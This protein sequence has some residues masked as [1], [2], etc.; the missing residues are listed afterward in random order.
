[1]NERT[2]SQKDTPDA[3]TLAQFMIEY[4]R[5]YLAVGGPTSRLEDSLTNL[6]QSLNVSTEV[7]ATPTGIF[8][9]CTDIQQKAFT[10]LARIRE[11]TIDLGRL[12]WLEGLLEDLLNRK[13][14]IYSAQKILKGKHTKKT[15]YS[16]FQNLVASFVFGF[17][18]SYPLYSLTLPALLSGLIATLTWYIAG[19][20]LKHRISSAIFRDF[21][22]CLF[23]LFASGLWQQI[24][25]APYE[26][27]SIWGIV[28]MVPGLSLTTAISELAE[29]NLVS[30]TAKLT[31]A[32]LTI[33]ALG[34]A[35]M[36]FQDV[37]L[38]VGLEN[39]ALQIVK[40]SSVGPSALAIMM[41][42]TCFGI[43]F[44]VPPKSLPW[45]TLCGVLGWAVLRLNDASTPVAFG[46]FSAALIV[47][48]T[49]IILSNRFKVP[50]QV[51]SVPGIIALLPG[52]LALN[53]FRSFAVGSQEMAIDLA[54]RV[55][56]TASSIVFG[57]LMAR[58]VRVNKFHLPLSLPKRL[59]NL[60]K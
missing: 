17:S 34:I 18:I 13:I 43:L 60:G 38:W 30:G 58:L 32:I 8:V 3:A 33:L 20:G 51:F 50:S 22:G 7:F 6:G 11:S 57:L 15:Y 54:F 46:T 29:Q 28:I 40:R 24:I 39:S 37:A 31:Q 21:A 27:F 25:R 1:M 12:C 41:S 55:A 10:T 19:P 56:V 48:I 53:S 59:K 4:G 44:R 9:S 16:M 26:S 35:Y 2:A 45:A 23:A 5:S 42:V 14:S 49:S 36:L 47:G 52:V